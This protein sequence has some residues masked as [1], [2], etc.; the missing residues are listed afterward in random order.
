MHL[1]YN[2]HW[3]E[4]DGQIGYNIY[5]SGGEIQH[6]YIGT[7]RAWWD[8]RKEGGSK[9]A[10]LENINQ[11]Q[12]EARQDGDHQCYVVG[13]SEDLLALRQGQVEHKNRCFD[14]RQRRNLEQDIQ[15]II[16]LETIGGQ[17]TYSTVKA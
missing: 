9:R 4:E 14:G 13:S 5:G 7:L 17:R 12:G 15:L 10:T 1:R 16:R 6:H 11:S 2:W 3:E 8:N